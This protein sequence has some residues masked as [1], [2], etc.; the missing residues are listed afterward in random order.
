MK[1]MERQWSIIRGAGV[2]VGEIADDGE[3]AVGQVDTDLVGAPGEGAGLQES[4][5]PAGGQDA[6][7]RAR[8]L[9]GK[10]T[11]SGTC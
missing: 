1:D 10:A 4:G 5:S 3:S 2:R 11:R 7:F 8:L 6:E 9:P